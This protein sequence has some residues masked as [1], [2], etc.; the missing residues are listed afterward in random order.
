MP[1]LPATTLGRAEAR[2]SLGLFVDIDQDF[3]DSAARWGDGEFPLG[4]A[5]ETVAQFVL[6]RSVLN[7]PFQ[8]WIWR[9]CRGR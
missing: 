1:Q 6:A 3:E 5:C 4:S 9:I 7:F 8:F 2:H